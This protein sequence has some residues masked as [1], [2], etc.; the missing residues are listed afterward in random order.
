MLGESLS[1]LEGLCAA[2]IWRAAA[3]LESAEP[4]LRQDARAFFLSEWSSSLL[5]FLGWDGAQLPTAL[6]PT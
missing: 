6:R 3:D 2:V 1:G 4:R 5:Q